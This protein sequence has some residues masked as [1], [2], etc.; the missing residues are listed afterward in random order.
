M[1]Q[2]WIFIFAP[3]YIYTYS[4]T[5]SFSVI[6]LFFPQ[7]LLVLQST[8]RFFSANNSSKSYLYSFLAFILQ[9]KKNSTECMEKF[10][11]LL[12]Y[13]KI[14]LWVFIVCSLPH[15]HTSATFLAELVQPAFKALAFSSRQWIWFYNF[16]AISLH[17]G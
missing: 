8:S 6:H 15:Y 2:P 9:E 16:S 7:P 12:C 4:F 1:L 11:F 3:L 5:S 13:V 14:T 10:F 17:I